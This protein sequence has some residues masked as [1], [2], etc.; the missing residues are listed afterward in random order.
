MKITIITFFLLTFVSISSAQDNYRESLS[1]A[2]NQRKVLDTFITNKID[3]STVTLE[4]ENNH[5]NIVIMNNGPNPM[6]LKYPCKQIPV[7]VEIKQNEKQEIVSKPMGC[8][9]LDESKILI[10]QGQGIRTLVLML[11]DWYNKTLR[12]GVKLDGKTTYSEW[13]KSK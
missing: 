10:S 2:L 4:I 7:F 11:D 9:Y 8:D 3:T 12:V 5:L 13:I 1:Q 6:T